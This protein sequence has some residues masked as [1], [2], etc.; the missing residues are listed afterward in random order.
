MKLYAGCY[1]EKVLEGLEGHGEGIYVFDFDDA[2]GTLSFLYKE[3]SRNASYLSLDKEK[4]L[5]YT[6][7][8][9]IKDK[10]PKLRTY[11]ISEKHLKLINEQD[12]SGGLPCHLLQI[13]NKNILAVACYE[14]GNLLVFPLDGKGIPNVASQEIKHQGISAN[15]LR[16][17]APHAH[18]ICYNLNDGFIYAPDLG[19]DKVIVYNVSDNNQLIENYQISVP[20]GGGPR[21]MVFHPSNNYAFIMNELTGMVSLLKNE[22][23]KFVWRANIQSLPDNPIQ[24]ASA[25]AIKISQSGRFIYCGNRS[26]SAISI[27]EFDVETESLKLIGSQSTFGKTPRDFTLDPSGKWL[28]VANQDSDTLVVFS[29]DSNTGLLRKVSENC[30]AKSVSCLKF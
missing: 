26:I 27:L 23:G 6:F 19:I 5:L 30:E 17:E 12:I 11:S 21:H 13:P 18:M 7:Q 24:D 2:N 4:Q 8:E 1:S 3:K 28:L 14:T 9:L 25:S 10:K 22:E 29:V 16:Q 20:K 15:A